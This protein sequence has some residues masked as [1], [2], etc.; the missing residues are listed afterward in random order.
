MKKN[1][2]QAALFVGTV[3][4]SGCGAM[5]SLEKKVASMELKKEKLANGKTVYIDY[6][7]TP[8]AV[9]GCQRKGITQ[10]YS[11]EKIRTE[12]SFSFKGPYGL[13]MSNALSYANANHLD[14]NYI[15]LTIPDENTTSTQSGRLSVKMIDNPNSTAMAD[16]YRCKKINPNKDLGVIRNHDVS[17]SG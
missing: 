17:Y 11:W 16:F 15:N 6:N 5:H 10:S 2:I 4:L 7:V 3:L 14:V 1:I 9:W 8:T 13:L 12:G